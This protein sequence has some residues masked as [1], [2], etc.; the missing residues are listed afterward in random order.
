M[1]L[2]LDEVLPTAAEIIALRVGRTGWVTIPGELETELGLEIKQAGRNRFSHVFI[3]GLS[4]DYLGYFL[5]PA[6]YRRPSYIACGSL[7]G[8]R[9]GHVIRDAALAALR[10]VGPATDLSW[11]R[12]RRGVP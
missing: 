9:G 4:N 10:R 7:Y 3:A 8:E 1:T 12:S 2:G 5:T 6:H 11:P